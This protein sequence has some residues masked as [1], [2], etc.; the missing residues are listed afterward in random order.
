M[1]TKQTRLSSRNRED[2]QFPDAAAATM[3]KHKEFQWFSKVCLGGAGFPT[4]RAACPPGGAPTLECANVLFLQRFSRF[5]ASCYR[6][7]R[8]LGG[9]DHDFAW[10]SNGFAT[11][12]RGR[13]RPC[14]FAA[15]QLCN[16]STFHVIWGYFLNPLGINFGMTF[17]IRLGSFLDYFLQPFGINFGVTFLNLFEINSEVSF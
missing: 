11:F 13:V 8:G 4:P 2:C 17:R 15:D 1:E 14:R 10:F 7:R 3:R 9:P 16:V 5:S 6:F 12:S